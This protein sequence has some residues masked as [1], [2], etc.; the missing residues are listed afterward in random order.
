MKIKIKKDQIM[1]NN[2]KQCG[3]TQKDWEELNNGKEI[4]M[5]K[6]PDLIKG[7]VDAVESVSKIDNKKVNKGVK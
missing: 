2:W 4:E 3:Y 7:Y 1:P 5:G 6:I